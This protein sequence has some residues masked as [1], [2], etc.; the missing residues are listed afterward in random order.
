MVHQERVG[1]LFGVLWRYWTRD[2]G[3]IGHG[4]EVVLNKGV[5]QDTVVIWGIGYKTKL[6]LGTRQEIGMEH[7]IFGW[8]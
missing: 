7:G 4:A 8:Y 2:R 1:I 5:A 6:M 3:D